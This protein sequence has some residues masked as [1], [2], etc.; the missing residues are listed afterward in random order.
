MPQG[1][2]VRVGLIFGGRSGEHEISIRSAASVAAAI[3]RDR[4][5]VTMIGIDLEGRWR[6]YSDESFR[7]ITEGSEAPALTEVVPVAAAGRGSLLDLRQPQH[8]LPPIDV[9]FPILH[10][11]YGEDGTIQG[12]LELADL[13]Y[14][15]A[16]VL[17]SAVGMDKDVQKR[18]LRDSGLPVVEFEAVTARQGATDPQEVAQRALALDLPVFVKPANL[19]SSIGI[20]KVA[21]GAA[22]GAAIEEALAYDTKIVIEEG[23]DARE[24]ECSVL[25]NEDPRASLP[26]EIE[27]GA[28]FYDFDAKY[29]ADSRARL[30]IPAP[31]SPSLVDQVRELAIAAFAATE[32][33]GMARV[34]F[35][36]ERSSDELYV[37]ELNTI[38]GF[39]SISMYAK[40]WEATGIPYRELITRLIELALERHAARERIGR[41]RRAG[42]RP[43]ST[44]QRD[45]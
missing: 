35:L 18:L 6:L 37:N 1:A 40:L 2:R 31:L 22:L 29:D 30:I 36:L 5:E 3:D 20:S 7:L 26:G 41:A 43:V 13:P 33:A 10:G 14:V 45:R 23:L 8:R 12:L 27:P 44:S 25:G 9:V 19:G 38:P 42:G 32:C 11:P 16:G 39:T 28:E 34:D 4:F 15:G 21:D 24:I 17:G